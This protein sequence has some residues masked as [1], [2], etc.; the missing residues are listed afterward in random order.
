ML[1][2]MSSRNSRSIARSHSS[3]MR[4]ALTGT[5][6]FTS[7][8]FVTACGSGSAPN[9]G[10]S[11][12]TGPAPDGASMKAPT[13]E[14]SPEG[15]INETAPTLKNFDVPERPVDLE[16]DDAMG[17]IVTAEYFIDLY[18]YANQSGESSKFEEAFNGDCTFCL[19]SVA[20]IEDVKKRELRLTGGDIARSEGEVSEDRMDS[21]SIVVYLEITQSAGVLL[22]GS[23]NSVSKLA[24]GSLDL[25]IQLELVHGQWVVTEVYGKSR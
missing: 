13:V 8:I 23:G 18:D 15:A 20:D 21:D 10:G 5:A 4:A 14:R 22:D 7:V 12:T 6:I 3:L 25:E 19:K 16:L 9:H 11:E 17:A 1:L 24:G 2:I